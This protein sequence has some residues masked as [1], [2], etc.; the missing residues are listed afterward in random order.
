M[1]RNLTTKQS[2]VDR[3]TAGLAERYAEVG[4]LLIDS[5]RKDSE[6]G[7][8]VQESE[9]KEAQIN[10]LMIE[11]AEKGGT[12]RRRE[13]QV[14]ALSAELTE[15]DLVR[16]KEVVGTGGRS[17]GIQD[18]TRAE[19][20][21]RDRV[22]TLAGQ[23]A[24]DQREARENQALGNSLDAESEGLRRELVRFKEFATAWLAEKDQELASLRQEASAKEDVT[25]VEFT[26]FTRKHHALETSFRESSEIV[27]GQWEVQEA[28]LVGEREVFQ[29]KAERLSG[30]VL[31]LEEC[32]ANERAKSGALSKEVQYV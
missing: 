10:C 1:S 11:S 30:G 26:E 3:L 19:G 20:V 7:R 6:V 31:R 9:E 4:R 16:L 25:M 17:H 5:A 2:V 18:T 21:E 15:K 32:V 29:E 23:V 12:L 22:R 14:R 24:T 8:L 13:I 28:K 27:Q